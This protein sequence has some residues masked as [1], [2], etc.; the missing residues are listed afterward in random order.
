MHQMGTVGGGVPSKK[1]PALSLLRFWR[2]RNYK[3]GLESPINSFK[4]A[5]RT[6]EVQK[7]GICKQQNI[8]VSLPPTFAKTNKK[9]DDS[10]SVG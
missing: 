2:F 10:H 8:V 5:A 3:V 9:I 1:R 6:V 4:R 7:N